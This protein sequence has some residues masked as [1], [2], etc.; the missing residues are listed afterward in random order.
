MTAPKPI[1]AARMRYKRCQEISNMARAL[2][3]DTTPDRVNR[4]YDVW[5]RWIQGRL[6][7]GYLMR[8]TGVK[9]IA[10]WQ[11]PE[12]RIRKVAHG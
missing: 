3:I 6:A 10:G 2:G 5:E 12:T 7:T 1:V 11:E 8:L 9:R 4:K